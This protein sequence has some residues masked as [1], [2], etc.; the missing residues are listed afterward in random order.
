MAYTLC[1]LATLGMKP[2][3]IKVL[4]A[5]QGCKT[6]ICFATLNQKSGYDLQRIRL[7]F[8]EFSNKGEVYFNFL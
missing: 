5:F 7:F 8:W 4:D 2:P 6:F 1:N 3:D